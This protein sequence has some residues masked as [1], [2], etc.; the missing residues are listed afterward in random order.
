MASDNSAK[1][2]P[3]STSACRVRHAEGAS[4]SMP[5]LLVKQPLPISAKLVPLMMS[6]LLEVHRIPLPPQLQGADAADGAD[7][8]DPAYSGLSEIETAPRR[9]SL[10]LIP[11]IAPQT[12]QNL[13]CMASGAAFSPAV[14]LRCSIG[15]SARRSIPSDCHRKRC[16]TPKRSQRTRL[17][18]EAVEDALKARMGANADHATVTQVK[19][20][21]NASNSR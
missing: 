9:A 8:R 20:Q 21:L 12:F 2:Y 3:R 19:K 6:P 5:R 4:S 10:A 1:A 11:L 16:D 15:L 14:C 7:G 13:A 18:A 17:V